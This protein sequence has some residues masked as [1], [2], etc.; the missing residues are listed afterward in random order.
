MKQKRLDAREIF[1]IPNIMG[2]F[3][4]VLIPV[5]C[6]LF[7]TAETDKDYLVAAGIVLVSTVTDF[8]DGL[9][10]RKCNMITEL[11]KF[12]D[13][14][15]DKL[16]HAALAVCLAYRYPLMLLIVGIMLIKEGFMAVMGIIKLKDGKKLDGAKWFGK[17]CT[18]TLF[19]VMCI[20]LLFP[21]MPIQIVNML[22]LFCAAVMV[23]TLIMYIPVFKK[24]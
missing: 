15:A 16:T 17:I 12:I 18:A 8:L 10:A 5:F 24:M 20:L 13:P 6:Y 7:F 19:L 4:V 3:R 14:L 22:I 21:S 9:V 2:Y 11:G 1:S 23:F